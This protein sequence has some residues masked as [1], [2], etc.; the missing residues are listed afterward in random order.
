MKD[1]L[2]SQ[3]FK[4]IQ[5]SSQL[6]DGRWVWIRILKPNDITD[7]KKILAV[8]R[9]PKRQTLS[10]IK[11]RYDGLFLVITNKGK[12]YVG[13]FIEGGENVKLLTTK[14]MKIIKS[15]NIKNYV[16]LYYLYQN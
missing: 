10:Q 6:R 13:A 16:K 1:E 7:I 9:K 2:S 3:I 14:G 5:E 15:R 4:V 11:R 8:K 12:R